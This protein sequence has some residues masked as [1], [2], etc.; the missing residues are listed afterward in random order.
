MFKNI[1]LALDLDEP[2]TW[3]KALPA[4]RALAAAQNA[5]LTL[6]T[7]VSDWEAARDA[8]WSPFGYQRMLDEAELGLR[9][10][11]EGSGVDPCEAKVVGGSI[12]RGI[13]DLAEQIDADLIVLASHRPGLKD[14]LIG[15][16]ALHVVRHATCSVLVVRE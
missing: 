10:I 7:V 6:G 14:Y 2:S 15:A 5:R 8:Q 3:S 4:A 13:L 1:L 11:A 9:R 12:G 16:N